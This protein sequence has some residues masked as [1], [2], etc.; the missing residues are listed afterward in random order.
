[1]NTEPFLFLAY[2]VR[3]P[4]GDDDED[5]DEDEDGDDDDDDE[6]AEH[7]DGDGFESLGHYVLYLLF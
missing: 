5:D 2:A 6:D 1:M 4:S 7:D 3:C